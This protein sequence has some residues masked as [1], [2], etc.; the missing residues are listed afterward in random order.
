MRWQI[1]EQECSL[2]SVHTLYATITNPVLVPTGG[3]VEPA[4]PLYA[5]NWQLQSSI[6]TITGKSRIRKHN[7]WPRGNSMI[8]SVISAR[9]KLP[10]RPSCLY[11]RRV[12]H[13]R[14]YCALS[15]YLQR[16]SNALCR[17][18]QHWGNKNLLMSSGDKWSLECTSRYAQVYWA[19]FSIP[20]LSLSLQLA[21]THTHTYARSRVVMWAKS[22][23]SI[24]QFRAGCQSERTT[25]KM[26]AQFELEIWMFAQ[27]HIYVFVC[28]RHHLI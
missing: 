2:C 5:V 7:M 15:I 9:N 13:V 11:Y 17:L 21:H 1:N 14:H 26:S 20:M 23:T 8:L 18:L 25:W 19:F 22:F 16:V 12:C 28:T 27:V 10:V 3:F 6:S 4:R 24:T